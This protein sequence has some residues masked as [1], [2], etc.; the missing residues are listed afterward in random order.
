M[1]R[2]IVLICLF[3]LTYESGAFAATHKNDRRDILPISS[4]S[5][6]FSP[7]WNVRILGG[8]AFSLGEA[9][10]ADLLSPSAQVSVGYRFSRL[11]GARVAF[12]GWQ[13]R[14]RYNYPRFDYTWNYVRSSAEIVL[15]VTSVL[16]GWR[17]GRLVSVNLFAGGGTAVGFRNIEANRA[18]RN[19]PDFQGLEKLW[20]GT[21][22]FWAARGGL[23]LDLRLARRLSICLE[24]DAGIFPDEFNSKVGKDSG[25]D[26]QFNC[27]VGLKFDLGR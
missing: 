15:D 20:A 6:T 12:N 17:E 24:S 1:M 4:V 11:L 25:F 13:A 14:N 8:G 21:R 2:K 5:G 23:E 9:G 16:A 10:F 22:F 7:E 19:N 26:W 3:M 27:L 18:R